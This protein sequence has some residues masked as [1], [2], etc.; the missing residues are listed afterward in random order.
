LGAR[1]RAQSPGAADPDRHGNRID[2]VEYHP[3]YHQLMAAAVARVLHGAAWSDSR[4]GAHVLRCAKTIVWSPV[5]YGHMCPL[6][7]SYSVIPALR[8]EPALAGQWEPGLT[9]REYDGRDLPASAK[10]GLTA[11]MAM[12]EKQGGSDVRANST[13]HPL[14][15]A[16]PHQAQVVLLGPDVG[17]VLVLAQAPGSHLS[18]CP[19][20]D[21]TARNAILIMRLR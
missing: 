21:P 15:T 10:P 6:S 19:A 11:G 1:R 7:M 14:P 18:P 20:T 17:P 3:A 16:T 8:T 13:I 5:D 9:G 4:P 2:R 12:T